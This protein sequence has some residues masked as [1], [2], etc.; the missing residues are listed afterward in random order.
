MSNKIPR[1]ILC[2][3]EAAHVSLCL[4]FGIGFD[5]V[6]FVEG[7]WSGHGWVATTGEVDETKLDGEVIVYLA[8]LEA[9]RRWLELH[10]GNGSVREEN[11]AGDAEAVKE[12]YRR[13]G[14]RITS[15]PGLKRRTAQLVELR[16]EHIERVATLL[17]A[18]RRLSAAKA[19]A[20][21]GKAKTA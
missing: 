3:H 7:F 8:G 4:H 17:E 13:Y 12:L 9:E 16:W 20:A 10:P 5:Y 15:L 1:T 18:S 6:K 21:H 2:H 19:K 14:S 11:G